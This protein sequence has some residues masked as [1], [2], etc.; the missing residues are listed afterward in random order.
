M[1]YF[2]LNLDI[3]GKK[4]LVVGGGQVALRKVERL[5]EC[6]AVVTV[7]S[8]EFCRGLTRM[9]GIKRIRRR[10]RKTDIRGAAL[11][12]S[13]TD[14]MGANRRVYEHATEAGIPVN[15]VDQP[16]LCSFTVPA[17]VSRGELLVTISTGGGSPA[18][19]ARIR[20]HIEEH[21]DAS[22]ADHLELLERMRPVVRSSGLPE[23]ARGVLLKG[24]AGEDVSRAL[25]QG[26]I[27]R[28]Q[29][30]ANE[31]LSRALED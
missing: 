22:F 15:V 25:K 26:G 29:K 30:V 28:A 19:S 8:P 1:R 6:C 27:K 24:M 16:E 23:E 21:L 20:R 31:M 9:R 17:V 4:A 10:Y 2:P 18:L 5:L 12:I 3:A 11:V 13:A 14:S 7:V